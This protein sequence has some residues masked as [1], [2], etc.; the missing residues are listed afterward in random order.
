[1]KCRKCK[2][3]IYAPKFISTTIKNEQI[4]I[5]TCPACG[6]NLKDAKKFLLILMI[7]IVVIWVALNNLE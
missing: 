2:S 5:A 4:R 1:M 7:L 3:E 6:G